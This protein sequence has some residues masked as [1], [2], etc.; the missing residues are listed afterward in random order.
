MNVI[1]ARQ[2][3]PKLP[4]LT[5][6]FCTDLA[7]EAKLQDVG[8]ERIWRRGDGLQS[9]EDA[10]YEF[11]GRPDGA[12]AITDDLRILGLT[13][14]AILATVSEITRAGV[15]I[16]SLI[17]PDFDIH[18]LIDQALGALHAAAPMR[19]HRTARRRGRIGGL[20][21]AASAA[22]ARA[23]ICAPEVAK[24]LCASRLTWEEKAFILG[25]PV[26]T[27]QRHYKT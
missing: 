8:V 23:V 11:R 1:S 10:L 13:R 20:A 27:I 4:P 18:Q 25:M 19:N 21:K 9:L 16:V 6:G 2:P 26:S 22:L 17:K 7:G 5:I 24:R 14:K 12:L 15:R 3:S